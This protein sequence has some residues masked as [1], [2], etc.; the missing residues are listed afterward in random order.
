MKTRILSLLLAVI[1]LA[2]CVPFFTIGAMAGEG[3]GS[4]TELSEEEAYEIY[5]DLYYDDGHLIAFI[6]T[7]NI[8]ADETVYHSDGDSNVTS[9]EPRLVL[10]DEAKY[11]PEERAAMTDAEKKALILKNLQRK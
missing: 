2:L 9:G 8:T 10:G 11:T 1:M 5:K 6:N 4:E 7:F 3:E